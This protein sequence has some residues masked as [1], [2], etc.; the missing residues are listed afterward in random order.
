[1]VNKERITAINDDTLLALIDSILGLTLALQRKKI[2]TTLKFI[3]TLTPRCSEHTGNICSASAT[4]ASHHCT[5][6]FH[7][8]Q[9]PG[10]RHSGAN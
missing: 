5:C 2:P 3:Q 4:N 10:C 7:W 6:Y 8:W 9:R 1:M